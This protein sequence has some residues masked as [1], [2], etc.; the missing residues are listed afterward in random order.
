[1]AP[2]QNTD[3]PEDPDA[4]THKSITARLE[5]AKASQAQIRFTLGMMA[6]ISMMMLIASYN[7]YFS[8]DYHWIIGE[9]LCKNGSFFGGC[10]CGEPPRKDEDPQPASPSPSPSPP[11][12]RSEEVSKTLRDQALKDWASSRIVLISLLG[13]RVS[14]DDSAVLGTSV[15]LI[16]SAWLLLWA[17]REN[18]TIGRLLRDTHKLRRNGNQDPSVTQSKSQSNLYS[19]R[20]RWLVF[21]TINSNSIFITVYPSLRSI[22]SL[23]GEIKAASAGFKGWLNNVMFGLLRNFFSLF[24]VVAALIVFVIDRRSYFI[25][26]PFSPYFQ[27]PGVNETFFWWS[28]W[29]FF[30][31]W[32]PLA[33]FCWKSLDYSRD[34]EQ[35]LRQY[36][37]K[38]KAERSEQE[39]PPQS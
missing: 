3:R 7:A 39:Q 21:H 2:H 18:H 12:S 9:E 4:E 26:D 28:M 16:L 29:V 13:I 15:L 8:Y 17:R 27:C 5:G 6:V 38:L 35:V 1:M 33:F 23:E 31:C 22:D 30:V 25:P 36:E 19:S 24:P 11:L 32:I 10:K 34:T 37:D 20:E 14:V